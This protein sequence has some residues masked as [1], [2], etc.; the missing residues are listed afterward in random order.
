MGN[1][2]R[3]HVGFGRPTA[4][5]TGARGVRARAAALRARVAALRA[6]EVGGQRAERPR[7]VRVTLPQPKRLEVYVV[8]LKQTGSLYPQVSDFERS[9]SIAAGLQTKNS[10]AKS[11]GEQLPSSNPQSSFVCYPIIMVTEVWP[12]NRKFET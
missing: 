3:Y 7:G 5:W 9:F 11:I 8:I 6:R 12:L 10:A 2:D 4:I 1:A